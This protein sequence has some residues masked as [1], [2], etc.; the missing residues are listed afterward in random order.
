[1]NAVLQRSVERANLPHYLRLEDRNSMAH[2]VE[3][4]LPFMDYRLV[5]LAF[6]LPADCKM[7]GVWNKILLRRGMR[8][9]IPESVR[10][11]VEKMGFPTSLHMWMTGALA[12]PL[13]DILSSRAARERGI[14]NVDEMLRALHNG[15]R[16]EPIAALQLFHVAEFELWHDIHRA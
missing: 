10:T 9:R 4:R 14:Y 3:A 2:G 1:L 13:R 6:R 8:G 11:R 16:L 12:D 7:E 5:S 15:R